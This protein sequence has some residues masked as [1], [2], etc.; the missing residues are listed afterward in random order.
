MLFKFTPLIFSKIFLIILIFFGLIGCTKID[1]QKQEDVSSDIQLTERFFK[2]HR[3]ADA[4]EEKL[5]NFIKHKYAN[6]NI[7]EK[8]IKI[9]GLPRWN[10]IAIY[11]DNNAS[12]TGTT[13][14]S[15]TYYIP[16]VI[17]T[18]NYVNA[19]MAIQTTATDTTLTFL[20][21]WQYKN[22]PNN[23]NSNA[24]IAEKFA[25]SF[26]LFDKDIFGFAK[27]K[28]LD[29]NLFRFNNKRVRTLS[30]DSTFEP[31]IVNGLREASV[32]INTTITWRDCYTGNPNCTMS[33]CNFSSTSTTCSGF[34]GGGFPSVGTSAPTSPP[35]SSGSTNTPGGG[36]SSGG[37]WQPLP[38]NPT[39]C[40][41]YIDILKNDAYFT[42]MFKYLQSAAVIS[43]Y[44]ETGFSVTRSAVPY[45]QKTG[46]DVNN[47]WINW[48]I[49]PGIK[50]DGLIHS[51]NCPLPNSQCAATI[52]SPQDIVFMAQIFLNGYA[53]DTNNLF[54]G[55]A[56][57]N[58]P[59]LVKITNP[60]KFRIFANKIAGN[61]E[62]MEE[63]KKNYD[64][65][66]GTQFVDTNETNF[67]QML[68]DFGV[69]NG[70]TLFKGNSDC[71]EWT[72]LKAGPFGAVE[73]PCETQ[74]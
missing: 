18:Q 42:S 11:K 60:V 6:D 67:L 13:S 24:G 69:G 9:V 27:F 70:L 26:M 15:N 12:V 55:V 1:I 63:F 45:V 33:G 16:L 22:L 54:L 8:I 37:G 52:F 68:E 3:T 21:D 71:N 30:I 5:V 28:I 56:N 66:L 25:L 46:T 74:D 19:A 40:D 34:G 47:P 35:A 31:N 41:P 14:T 2:E 32:C 51:H 20:Q 53:K 39:Y 48:N 72:K 23:T 59:Y 44:V 17:N 7:V 10:K 57:N 61:T 43:A 49:P 62:K 29:S 36:T 4:T 58:L 73:D 50:V 65:K 64:P 38:E